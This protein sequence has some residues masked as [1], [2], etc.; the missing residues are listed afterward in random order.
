MNIWRLCAKKT[1]VQG[2]TRNY[3]DKIDINN[4]L[5]SLP[6]EAVKGL[7]RKAYNSDRFEKTYTEGPES[8]HDDDE[9]DGVGQEHQH[10]DVGDGAVL[11]MDQVVEELSH[12]KVDVHEPT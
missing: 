3:I 12:G 10:V 6:S 5:S 8:K 11:G 4:L 2:S 1:F 7:R 9:V